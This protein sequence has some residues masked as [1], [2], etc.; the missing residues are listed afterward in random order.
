MKAILPPESGRVKHRNGR[1]SNSASETMTTHI[2][3]RT[4]SD[5][6][7]GPS[8]NSEWNRRRETLEMSTT[9]LIKRM[10][11]GVPFVR[12]DRD[13]MCLNTGDREML[14]LMLTGREATCS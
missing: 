11:R 6:R 13:S 10:I 14:R 2:A 12:L 8:F 7:V 9:L 4:A 5:F 3:G 1:L